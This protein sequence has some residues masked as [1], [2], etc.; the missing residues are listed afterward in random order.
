MDSIRRRARK[1]QE[2]INKTPR[3]ERKPNKSKA[4]AMSSFQ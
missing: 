4:T 3:H 2:E 1:E